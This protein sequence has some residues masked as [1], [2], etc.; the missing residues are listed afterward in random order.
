MEGTEDGITLT[1][2]PNGVT[3][4]LSKFLP[5]YIA[6]NIAFF[7]D[8]FLQ[9]NNLGRNDGERSGPWLLFG[10]YPDHPELCLY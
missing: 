1:I 2:K 4:T 6:K 9:K 10:P 3:G 5:K 7:V 8:G